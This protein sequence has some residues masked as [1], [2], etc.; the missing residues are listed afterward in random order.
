MY[1]YEVYNIFDDYLNEL[2]YD[3]SELKYGVTLLSK[4]FIMKLPKKD[5]NNVY[6]EYIASNVIKILGGCVHN[7][8]LGKFKDKIVCLCEDFTTEGKTLK[9]FSDMN[10][11]SLD[12]DTSRH[13]YYFDDVMYIL[14]NIRHA[15][16]QGLKS[17]FMSMYVYDALLGN[18]DRHKGNWGLLKYNGYYTFAPIFDNGACLFPRAKTCGDTS[19][20]ML[21]RIKDFPN[22][23]IMFN[24]KRERSSYFNVL[25]EHREFDVF[26]E[27]ITDEL[28][29]RCLN[30]ITYTP[31]PDTLK[32]LYRTVLYYRYHCIIKLEDF[33]WRG[34]LW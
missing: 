15:D 11:S 12:T 21:E 29:D 10:S 6:C 20:W 2:N 19:D 31:I 22:S 5:W 33:V 34:L 25:R 7:V 28:I 32:V 24:N 16:V 27:R 8:Y 17:D 3:G 13:N 23:K 1:V 14:S 9:T 26:R 30:F 4:N 18:P